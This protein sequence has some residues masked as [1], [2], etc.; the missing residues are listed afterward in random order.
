MALR[1][2]VVSC[3]DLAGTEDAVGADGVE[4]TR[5]RRPPLSIG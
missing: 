4:G 5:H 2:C 3:R 1:S